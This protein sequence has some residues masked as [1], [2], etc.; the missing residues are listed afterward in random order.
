[1]IGLSMLPGLG[2]ILLGVLNGA[3]F[4]S[5]AWYS[6]MS[7]VSLWGYQLYRSFDFNT[8]SHYKLAK[9]YRSTT[10]FYYC[11]FSLWTAIFLLYIPFEESNLHYI[12]LFTQIGTSVVASSLLF[13]DKRLYVPIILIVI[14]PLIIY[15]LQIGTWYGYVLTAFS[16]VFAWVLFYTSSSS[17]RLLQ[18]TTYQASRDQLTGLFNRNYFVDAMQQVVNSLKSN[19]GYCY[20]LLID[21]DY[22]K[23]INDSL[24][25]DVG[26]ILLKQVAKRML[27][28]G[29][30]ESVIAR[31]GGDEFIVVGNIFND[32]ESCTSNAMKLAEDLRNSLKSAYNIDRHTLY[33][34]ASIGMSILHRPDNS[35]NQYIKEADIAMYEV[36]D[37][38]RDGIVVFG[39]E[40]S[41]RIEK[42]LEIERLLRHAL[43][44]KEF[45][46]HYQPQYNQEHQIVGCEALL[47]WQ[48]EELGAISPADFIPI[49]EKTGLIIDIG[50]FVIEEAFSTLKK[51]H[52]NGINLESISINVSMR[53]FY[54]HRFHDDIDRLRQQYLTPDLCKKIIF[55]LTES[56]MADEL[57]KLINLMNQLKT[58]G[59]MFS[60]DDFGTGYSSLAYLRKIPLDEIK[61]DRVFIEEIT[62]NTHDQSMVELI[63]NLS[64][65][66]GLKVVAEGIENQQQE[67]L[68]LQAG[69]EIFQGFLFSK[70]L[71]QKSFENIYNKLK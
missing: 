70:P 9:W 36:K 62:T 56:V 54:H 53:Q 30:N 20:L 52:T 6:M 27:D 48:S 42:H 21:L 5:I 68:L 28:I 14:A 16:S 50:N 8:M 60:I 67:E 65:V 29:S 61:I 64:K 49:A 37:K 19:D 59:F 46:L 41:E 47:R 18:K 10:Y 66:F 35:A 26:D 34:S 15:F 2:Y 45:Y 23:T 22:F 25:H 33:I 69:C 40:I 57:D 63:L 24:G 39:K 1:M 31:M 58:H 12:A 32:R 38:G 71:G 17:N 7:L 55:E 51:W 11:I 44:N 4:R 13:S 3:V 43:V